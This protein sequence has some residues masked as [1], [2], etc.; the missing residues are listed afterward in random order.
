[1]Q[2]AAQTTAPPPPACAGFACASFVHATQAR[3]CASSDTDLTIT[4]AVDSSEF[5]GSGARTAWSAGAAAP[6][7]A[8]NIIVGIPFP[9]PPS[10]C[11]I[12]AEW[13]SPV[14]WATPAGIA[15]AARRT[16]VAFASP[17][18]LSTAA[19]RTGAVVKLPRVCATGATPRR[20]PQ[21]QN[22]PVNWRR[23]GPRSTAS[24]TAMTSPRVAM[25]PTFSRRMTICA[26]TFVC[27]F[28]V[29]VVTSV[30]MLMQSVRSITA[31]DMVARRPVDNLSASASHPAIPARCPGGNPAG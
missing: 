17:A 8:R 5:T 2:H 28:P 23:R 4:F 7:L 31:C 26:E 29:S 30:I 24:S 10:A 13:C 19:C 15:S 1:M 18:C 14:T 22:C 3:S 27:A 25:S 6:G 12:V 21:Q 11:F 16:G 9:L 20:F